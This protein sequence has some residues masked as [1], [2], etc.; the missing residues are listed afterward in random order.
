[1]SG[2][3]V[4]SSVRALCAPTLKD[5]IAIRGIIHGVKRCVHD[6][7]NWKAVCICG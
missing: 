4:H 1:M 6:R 5:H 2:R 7:A 3:G